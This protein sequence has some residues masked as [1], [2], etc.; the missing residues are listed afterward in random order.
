[1]RLNANGEAPVM[2]WITYAGKRVNINLGIHID[3]K[4]WDNKR[5]K[6]KGNSSLVKEYNSLLLTSTT[7]MLKA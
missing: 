5:Q 1:M 2:M 6:V 4:S 7:K 3:P